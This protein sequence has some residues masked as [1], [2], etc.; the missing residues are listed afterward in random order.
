MP[1]HNRRDP[2]FRHRRHEEDVIVL[3]VRR[4]I[5]YRLSLR[6]LVE[7]LGDRGLNLH[8]STIWRWIQTF[9][10]EFEKLWSRLLKP[11]GA[12][13]R[14]DET[15]VQI[16]GRWCYLYR[17]IDR[18]G[19]T[20]DFLLRRD[21]G[22]PAAKVF[23]R[24]ALASSLPRVPRKVTIDGHRPTLGA[25]WS[26]RREHPCWCNV[27]VRTN[28]YLNNVIEQ[29]HRAVKRRCAAIHGLKSFRASKITLAGVGLAHR[30]R[31]RQFTLGHARGRR[32]HTMQPAWDQ[33][34]C[35]G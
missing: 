22:V 32:R 21:R 10:P 34:V 30:I 11:V 33:A 18:N 2:M 28:R 29:D 4:Y 25:L 7:M 31:K 12:S 3:A 6:D 16:R 19:K 27:M 14:V 35:G 24:K 13:W 9:V 1:R 26:L 20:V 15:Y 17:A 23:F 8:L 5:S